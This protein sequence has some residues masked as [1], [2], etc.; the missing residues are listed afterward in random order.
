MIIIANWFIVANNIEQP[1]SWVFLLIIPL[2]AVVLLFL[3]FF[4]QLSYYW[5]KEKPAH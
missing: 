3:L 4:G 2:L 1:P 5:M